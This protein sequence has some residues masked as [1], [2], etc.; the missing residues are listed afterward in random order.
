MKKD[1][2]KIGQLLELDRSI[3]RISSCPIEKKIFNATRQFEAVF[4]L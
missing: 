1:S 3:R 4:L 2:K